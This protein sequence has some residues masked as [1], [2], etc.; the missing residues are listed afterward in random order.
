VDNSS[1]IVSIKV[2]TAEYRT[3]WFR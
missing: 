3:T 1:G 2:L